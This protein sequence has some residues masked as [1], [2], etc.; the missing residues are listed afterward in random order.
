MPGSVCLLFLVEVV[1]QPWGVS[2]RS[3]L[4]GFY[5]FPTEPPS[6]LSETLIH[7]SGLGL[8]RALRQR[9]GRLRGTYPPVLQ[10]SSDS[11]LSRKDTRAPVFLFR[12]SSQLPFTGLA[13]GAGGGGR[14]LFSPKPLY[15][16][17]EC[18]RCRDGGAV[19]VAEATFSPLEERRRVLVLPE[20]IGNFL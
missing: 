1:S 5:G 17:S 8:G 10:G 3:G 2:F 11:K 9:N 18:K 15:P 14:W 12:G 7:S 6:L 19:F 13:R 4:Y 16:H 20:A